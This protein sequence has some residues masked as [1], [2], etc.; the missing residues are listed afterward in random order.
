[1]YQSAIMMLEEDINLNNS[2][3][4]NIFLSY[5]LLV[6]RLSTQWRVKG[7]GPFKAG[8]RVRFPYRERQEA[9]NTRQPFLASTTQEPAT[10]QETRQ[11]KTGG[12]QHP[13]PHDPTKS[14]DPR[15][16]MLDLSHTGYLVC[17]HFST[18]EDDFLGQRSDGLS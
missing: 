2:S 13:H 4:T 8:G 5:S 17:S 15:R 6:Y 10:A 7:Y 14:Y 1:M 3:V 16:R 12:G 18:K 9:G 11:G